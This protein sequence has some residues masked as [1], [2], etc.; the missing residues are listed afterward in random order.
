M[1]TLF[2]PALTL[3]LLLTLLLG[4]AAPLAMTGVAQ[5]V[6]PS[7]AGGSLIERNGQVIGSALIGQNFA[8]PRYFHPRPSATTEPD[9]EN[10]GSTRAAPYNAAS[11][12]ASQQ[13]PTSAALLEAIRTRVAEAGLTPVPADAVTASGSGLDPHISPENAARQIPRVATARGIPEERVRALLAQYIEGREL[14]LLGEPHVN[15]L[16]LNLALD[17]LR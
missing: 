13:G 11:S 1:N 17:D 6:F 2:R 8:E 10:E 4:V 14:G 16:R 7:Q 9:P 12:A 5:V 15:V 3:V